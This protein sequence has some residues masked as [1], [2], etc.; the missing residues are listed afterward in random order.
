MSPARLDRAMSQ[1]STTT[2]RPLLVPAT[3]GC[4]ASYPGRFEWSGGGAET[5]CPG[6]NSVCRKGIQMRK[7]G[8][9]AAVLGDSGIRGLSDSSVYCPEPSS[10]YGPLRVPVSSMQLPVRPVTLDSGPSKSGQITLLLLRLGRTH[11]MAPPVGRDL[12]RYSR[13]RRWRPTMPTTLESVVA[14]YL[15]SGNPAQRT[16]EEYSTTWPLLEVR[17]RCLLQLWSRHRDYLEDTAVS[18]ADPLAARVVAATIITPIA[19]RWRSEPS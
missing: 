10:W 3:P 19:R 15:R 12:A 5:R 17:P 14:K 8:V 2:R 13:R 18:R 4:V 1:L 11:S 9:T 6:N 16:R 7:E